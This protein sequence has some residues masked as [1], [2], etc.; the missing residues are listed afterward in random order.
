MWSILSEGLL[1]KWLPLLVCLNVT[2]PHSVSS[3]VVLSLISYYIMHTETR[4]V[5][6][7]ASIKERQILYTALS[8]SELVLLK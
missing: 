3:P 1:H 5:T 4:A 2:S 8:V 6:I 7:S